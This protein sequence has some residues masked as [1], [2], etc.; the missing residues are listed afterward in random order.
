MH[1]RK[2]ASHC[3]T[4]D[5]D[6]KAANSVICT[7]DYASKSSRKTLHMRCC[8]GCPLYRGTEHH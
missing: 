8:D 5:S 2:A 6:R 4:P 7:G 3:K 1:G